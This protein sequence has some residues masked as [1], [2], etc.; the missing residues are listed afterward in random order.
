MSIVQLGRQVLTKYSL[1]RDQMSVKIPPFAPDVLHRLKALLKFVRSAIRCLMVSML[2]ALRVPAISPPRARLPV[3]CGAGMRQHSDW[4][5][6]LSAAL[7]PLEAR[8]KSFAAVEHMNCFAM[9][10]V[11]WVTF[12]V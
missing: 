12:M 8:R 4:Y 9:M 7:R 2:A 1:A 6:S 11:V 5:S 3:Q 10:S